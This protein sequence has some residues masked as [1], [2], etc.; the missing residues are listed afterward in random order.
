MVGA[1]TAVTRRIRELPPAP[2][3]VSLPAGAHRY[4]IPALFGAYASGGRYVLA[5]HVRYLSAVITA[6]LRRGDARII[7]ELPPRFGKSTFC[8]GYLPPWTAARRRVLRSD[9]SGAPRSPC[10]LRTA[11]A[12]SDR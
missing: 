7:V 3:G 10:S 1:A 9:T 11:G 5:P 6:A 12:V 8:S 2:A 4:G